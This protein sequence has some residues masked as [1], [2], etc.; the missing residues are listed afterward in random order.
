MTAVDKLIEELTDSITRQAGKGPLWEVTAY[1]VTASQQRK[2]SITVKVNAVDQH[3][4]LALASL[5]WG[6]RLT[7]HE[8]DELAAYVQRAPV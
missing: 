6:D 7:C 1:V 4:A 5:A 3:T 8:H 2:F